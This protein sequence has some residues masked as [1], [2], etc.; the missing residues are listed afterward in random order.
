MPIDFVLISFCA[1]VCVQQGVA[2]GFVTLFVTTMVAGLVCFNLARD[3]FKGYV[4]VG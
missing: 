3:H 1:P 4:Q 2:L